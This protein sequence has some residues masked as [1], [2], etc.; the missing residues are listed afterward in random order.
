M[1][2]EPTDSLTGGAAMVSTTRLCTQGS[3]EPGEPERFGS[4]RLSWRGNGAIEPPAPVDEERGSL[5]RAV[6]S[7]AVWWAMSAIATAAVLLLAACGGEGGGLGQLFA[8]DGNCL[9]VQ[10]DECTCDPSD[11]CGWIGDGFCDV[12]YCALAVSVYFDDTEDCGLSAACDG[13][14]GR[15]VFNECTCSTDDPCNW[16]NDGYCD[17]P[18]CSVVS[19]GG[20]FDDSIDCQGGGGTCDGDCVSQ[21]YSECTCGSS[22]PCGWANNGRCDQVGCSQVLSSGAFDDSADCS[23]S[24]PT[25]DL[26]FGVTAV[27]DDLDNG[28]LTIMANGLT[29]LGYASLVRD[30]NVTTSA[31]TRYLGQNLTLLY[32]T[33]HGYDGQV[34]TAD[35]SISVGS[36]TLNVRHTI[37][38]TCLT[39]VQSWASAF[40]SSAE[41]VLGY[42]KVSYDIIDDDVANRFLTALGQGQS[43]MVAWYLANSPISEVSDRWA[44]Y[45]NEA[46]R[47]VEYSARSGRT[48][49][50]PAG[51]DDLSAVLVPLG[52]AGNLW[53]QADL[54]ADSSLFE[55][56]APEIEMATDDDHRWSFNPGGWDLLG[57]MRT[58]RNEAVET[59]RYFVERRLGGM[60]PDAILETVDEVMA[61]VE[62]EA[63]V[64]VGYT[65]SWSRQLNGLPVRGNRVADHVRLLVGPAGVA[66]WSVYW[67]ELASVPSSV[68][69]EQRLLPVGRAVELAADAISQACKGEV[70]LIGARPVYGTLGPG[71][72][73]STLVPAYALETSDGAWLVVDALSGRLL[74]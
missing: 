15:G 63:P 4:Q 59:A 71:S 67:P 35:G 56:S 66:A 70:R 27:R 11:P 57:P 48:P 3:A 20:T 43:P 45:V 10:Y 2:P 39:L 17:E 69:W 8:C 74:R 1:R 18:Q 36:A 32:H 24:Q 41:T 47:I 37:F 61:Q 31:L 40:G 49:S 54:L 14:C 46:G 5:V 33:G 44:G 23:G 72:R 12:S 9:L 34:Q 28:D 60:P 53:V 62:G 22:D 16:I 55:P 42:T 38:A 58:T 51:F 65:V 68:D 13:S 19:P 7:P 50:A 73:Q 6:R 30:T 26:T 21:R 25:G 52:R 29:N 64:I